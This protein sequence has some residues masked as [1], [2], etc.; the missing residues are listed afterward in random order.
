MT[1]H[2]LGLVGSGIDMSL[3]PAFHELAGERLGLDIGYELV[4]Q[5]PDRVGELEVILRELAADGFHGVNVTVP[6]KGA[7]ARAAAAPAAEVVATGVANTVLLGPDGPGRAHNTDYSGFKWAYGRRFGATPPGTVAVLGAGGVGSATAAALVDLGA[8][9]LRVYDLVTERSLALAARLRAA[10][11]GGGPAIDVV[12]ATT[13]EDAVD[14]ADG[15][16]NGTPVGMT[17]SPGTPVDLAAV[18][19][20]RWVFDAVYSPIETPLMARAAA[21]GLD[22][23]TGFDLFLG[24]AIDAFAIFTGHRLPAGVVAELATRLGI[25]ERERDV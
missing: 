18:G 7:A 4:P 1:T 14:G 17:W 11:D 22:R 15:I 10:R 2:R 24:Q 21:A 9:A 3:T 20:Q 25:L 6:F 16:V 8:R 23:V 5:A 12:A 19:G 13:A